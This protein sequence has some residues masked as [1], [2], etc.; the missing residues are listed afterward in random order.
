MSGFSFFKWLK[1][2]S[3]TR[4]LYFVVGIMALLIAIELFTLSFM[5]HTLSS[6][7]ALVEAEG[8]WSK[9]Q[10][11]A[12]YSLT[13]YGY[14]HNDK[15][16]QQYLKLLAVPM[17]DR[18]ARL[19]LLKPDRNLNIVRQG[20]TEGRINPDDIDGCIKLLTRF[21]N[22][23]YIN[24]AITIWTQGDY[25]LDMLQYLGDRL[26]N[27]VSYNNTPPDKI[28]QT[29]DEIYQLNEKLTVLEDNFSSTLGEGSR[30]IEGLILKILFS[31]AITVEFTGLFLTISVSRAISKG[32]NE[33]VRIA[34]KVA[35]A[36][37]GDKAKVFS[38]DEIGLLAGSFNQMIDDLKKKIEEEKEAEDAL[39]NQ[40]DLYETLLKTESEMGEG[41]SITEN[42]KI[43]YVNDAVCNIYGYT[44]EEILS[45]SSFLDLVPAEEKVLLKERLQQRIAGVREQ[46]SGETKIQRKDGKIIDIEYTVRNIVVDRNKQMLSIIRD[47]TEKK[48]A[49]EQLRKEKQRAE[50]AEI[51]KKVGEQFLAN[52]SHEI[53]TPMNA[54]VGFTD[55]ILKTPLSPEQYQYL[56][57]IKTSGDNLLVIINDILD[58]SRMRSGKIPI[59]QRA[60]KLSQIISTCSELMLQ[61]ASEKG[62]KLTTTIEKGIQDDLIGDATRLNQ[63][64][65][66]L[67]ANALKFTSKGGV[68][69][70]VNRLSETE[71]C[72]GLEFA[73]QD[74]GIGIPKDK[75]LTIFEAFTQANNDTA[76]R[77][78]GT[79]LG[80][81]IVKQLADLQ[82]GSVSVTSEEGKGSCFYFRIKYRKNKMP[83]QKLSPK[84]ASKEVAIKN[85]NVLLVE[86]NAMNQLL[87]QKVLG[88]WGWKVETVE[89]GIEAIE[90][91]RATDFDVV[92]MDIQ[93]PEMDGYEATKQ[94]RNNIPAPKC[95]VP[96]MAM[97]AHVMPSE[98]DRCY[99]AGMNAYISKPFDTKALYEKIAK[100]VKSK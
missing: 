74:T 66:N 28:N 1:N 43:I 81:A 14:T 67:V 99:K 5:V 56:E 9:A 45:M 91:V 30:W 96:I 21:H 94:I 63:V 93:M 37:F 90:K 20:F 46:S 87:A 57:A 36:D 79:G 61:R 98:E 82:E 51:A 84:T 60:F 48:L 27:Q 64:L 59:E 58:F 2:I 78:G 35:K 75:L 85:V 54:I 95:N 92:L 52:M 47:V 55:V 73:I 29:Q 41:V 76:R 4:K 50:S 24:N 25:F 10:K 33:V 70:T 12:V 77:Y 13:K 71:E 97:T 34:G 68:S 69:I 65:I 88:D 49:E 17:G 80:L 53:R 62:I 38:N 44:R 83:A 72:I 22:I 86:D 89:N 16:Y 8:L 42:D 15:D 23:S 6:T 18:K 32:I 100:L 7:R 26:H 19:E 3:L 11:D 39:R 40:K 31:I